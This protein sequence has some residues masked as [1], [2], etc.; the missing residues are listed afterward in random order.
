VPEPD[1]VELKTAKTNLT[2]AQLVRKIP[3]KNRHRETDWGKPMGG[4]IVVIPAYIPAPETSSGGILPRMPEGSRPASGGSCSLQPRTTPN[5]VGQLS[6]Q[7]Q[8]TEYKLE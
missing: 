7:S 3:V 5:Q 1:E 4:R 6:A 8:V 2:L